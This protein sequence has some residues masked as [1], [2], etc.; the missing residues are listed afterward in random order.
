MKKTLRESIRDINNMIGRIDHPVISEG[1]GDEGEIGA[2]E[3]EKGITIPS[4]KFVNIDK[5]G[6]SMIDKYAS[7]DKTAA[8]LKNQLN[9]QGIKSINDV[10]AG[11]MVSLFKKNKIPFS[12]LTTTGKDVKAKVK[13]GAQ[14]GLKTDYNKIKDVP[15]QA[16][17]KIKIP[18]HKKNKGL[19]L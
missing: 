6:F 15:L 5:Q 2:D 1:P 13:I 8:E 19:K 4:T 11:D 3:V 7:T 9:S 18:V 14:L 16:N 17:A 12:L 10:K